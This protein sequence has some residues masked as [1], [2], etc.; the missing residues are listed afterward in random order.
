VFRL[1]RLMTVAPGHFHAA[2]VQ[3]RAMYGVHPRAHVYGPLDGDTVA[4]LTRLASFNNRFDSPTAWEVDLRAGGDYLQRFVREQPGN[5]VVLSGRNRPKI[6]LMRLA[7]ENCLHVLADKPWIIEH[8]DFPK[9]E[10][11]FR[12]AE[13]REALVWDVLTERFE[14]TNWLQREL[15]RDPEVFGSWQVGSQDR[16]ALSLH[17]VHHLKKIVNGQPLVRPWW[18]FEPE[19]SGE[20]MADVGTHLADLAIWFIAP[21]QPV[22]HATQIQMLA[23]DRTPLLLSEDEFRQVTRLAG[24]P[25]ELRSRVVA[26]QLYYAGNNTASLT[27]RGVH[28]RLSTAWEFESP[29]GDAHQSYARGTRATISVRQQPSGRP[30]L[31]I[32]AADPGDHADLLKKLR[33]KCDSLQREFSGFSVADLGSEMQVLIPESWRTGHEEH[34]AA[35]MDEFV[36][37]FHTPRAVPAWERPNALARYYITTKAVEMARAGSSL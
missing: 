14:V 31:Y 35:V 26:G 2:L 4:H 34:F 12:E 37:Y 10:A 3:K 27:L 18:W 23:A 17:S 25:A 11:L 33:D 15:V 6:D 29:G 1:I 28:V 30:E 5:T 22:D 21:E 8:A 20:A 32:S 16:P 13:L 36:R 19:I 9:L 7:V 24:Y